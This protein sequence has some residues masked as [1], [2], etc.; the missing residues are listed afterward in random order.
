MLSRGMAN[1]THLLSVTMK[2]YFSAFALLL[3][4]PLFGT[5]TA[6]S[7]ISPDFDARSYSEESGP[8]YIVFVARGGSVTGHAYVTWVAEDRRRQMSVRD[9]RGLYCASEDGDTCY[10]SI[11]EPYDGEFR[12][13]A[14][15]S[16]PHPETA[17]FVVQVNE[18]DYEAAR[19]VQADWDKEGEYQ[20]LW[21]DCVSYVGDVASTIGLTVPSRIYVWPKTYVQALARENR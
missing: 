18:R 19:R 3:I 15:V 21:G 20:L 2:R 13:E 17:R 4:L 16:R 10:M 11:S 12:N 14:I 7:Q 9:S 5:T 8:Y 1:F 6:Y